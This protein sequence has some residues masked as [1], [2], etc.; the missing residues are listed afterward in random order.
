VL[1]ERA[2]DVQQRV[3]AAGRTPLP[4]TIFSAPYDATKL[5][6]LAEVGVVRVVTSLRPTVHD[7]PDPTRLE[8][9]LDVIAEVEQ[10]VTA[11]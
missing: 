3:R 8:R 7:E 10:D 2:R 1:L 5:R 9:F 6:E 11:S 4:I